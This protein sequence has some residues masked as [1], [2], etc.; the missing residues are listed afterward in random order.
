MEELNEVDTKT[1]VKNE[2]KHKHKHACCSNPGKGDRAC[3]SIPR[4]MHIFIKLLIIL[5]V[6][7]IGVCIGAH[8][9]RYS[10]GGNF[11]GN[12]HRQGGCAMMKGNGNYSPQGCAGMGMTGGCPMMTGTD[13]GGVISATVISKPAVPATTTK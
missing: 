11:S 7:F 12:Y 8:S 4:G 1:E 2:H 5:V 9:N 6:F 10:D 3:C 13:N